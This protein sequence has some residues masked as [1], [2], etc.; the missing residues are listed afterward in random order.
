VTGLH[1]EGNRPP[2]AEA[3]PAA[4]DGAAPPRAAGDDHAPPR[5]L[6]RFALN[7]HHIDDLP[8]Y[9]DSI[10]AVAD[11]GSSALIV[12]TP[13]YQMR[14]DSSAIRRRRSSC[15]TEEQLTAILRRG[16]ERDLYPIFLMPIVLIETPQERQSRSVIEP[17]DWDAGWASYDGFIDHFVAV[18][19]EANANMFVVGSELNST[20]RQIDRWQRN[21][22]RARAPLNGSL[23]YSAN[24]HRYDRVAFWP[25][26][27][28]MSVSA[29]F[30]LERDGPGAPVDALVEAWR[31]HRAR[32][33]A[34]A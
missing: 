28:A 6:L 32:L 26:A 3:P 7:C 30:E 23:T 20:E 10:D 16:L 33:L 15:P 14:V 4:K 25:L 8:L 21:V 34:T 24:W 29:C 1:Y 11:L 27:D 19:N 5:P 12:V 9:L 17:D 18:A 31:P 13:M 2:A 22:G